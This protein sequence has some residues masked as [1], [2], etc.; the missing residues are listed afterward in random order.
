[1]KQQHQ[2]MIDEHG[3]FM[4]VTIAGVVQRFR[5]I[6]AGE[7]MMGSPGDEP[8]R[9]DDERQH[10]KSVQGFWLADTACTQELWEAVMRENPSHFKGPQRP[11]ETVSE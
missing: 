1:M 8:G 6:P 5:W 10:E 3:H 9:F 11:V 7:F 4:D 2:V